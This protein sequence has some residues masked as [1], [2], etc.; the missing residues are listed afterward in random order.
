MYI[1]TCIYVKKI[2]INS[3]TVS[4]YLKPS[5]SFMYLLFLDV[6]DFTSIYL[7]VMSLPFIL[8]PPSFSP[9]INFSFSIYLPVKTLKNSRKSHPHTHTQSNPTQNAQIQVTLILPKIHSLSVLK[10][11]QKSNRQPKL[12]ARNF[13]KTTSHDIN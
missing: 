9:S 6:F 2:T 12:T 3:A 10:T 7:F 4:F 1:H 13:L 11:L 5:S 8:F